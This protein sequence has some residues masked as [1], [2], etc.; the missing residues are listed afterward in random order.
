MSSFCSPLGVAWRSR[1]GSGGRPAG[2][3]LAHAG[4]NG[5][6]AHSTEW[7]IGIGLTPR[8]SLSIG[9]LAVPDEYFPDFVRG[10][11]DGD[12]SVLVYTDRHHTARKA[13]YVY[14]RLYV[15]L[16]SASRRFIDWIR[17]TIERL[18]GLRGGVHLKQ[19]RGRRPVWVL[20][21]S[22]KASAQLLAWMYYA[23]GVPCLLRK[24]M[25]AK[26]FIGE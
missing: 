13:S 22:K 10:C 3:V 18:V 4:C 16:V 21:Y 26:P 2:S 25:K 7:L 15:S 1:I 6:I 11:I 9:A 24:R 12:G 5:G 23:P 8:K 17:A 20:R 19:C 14:T